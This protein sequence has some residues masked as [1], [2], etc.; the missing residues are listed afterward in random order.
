MP[1]VSGNIATLSVGKQ[2][3]KGT[4]QATPTYKMKLTG[5]NPEAR[6]D[7]IQLA[8]TDAT[9]QQGATVV[10][11]SRVEGT[12]EHYIRPPSFGL[13]AYLLM[14][15]NADSGAGPY[16]HTATP[17]NSSPYATLFKAIG[18]TVLVD[19]YSDC[20]VQSLTARGAAGGA[21]TCSVNWLGLTP[22]H[23]SSDPVL[24]A[25]ATTPLVYPDVTVTLAASTAAI[26]EGFEL[27]ID[28][29]TQMIQGDT[30]LYNSDMAHGELQ[31]RGTLTMLFESDAEYRRHLTGTPSGTVPTTSVASQAL[32]IT[33]S[34]GAT[35]IVSFV[36]A[37]VAWTEVPVNPDPGGAP[38]KV[39]AGFYSLPQAA[40]GDYAK[41][42][43]TN[44]VVTY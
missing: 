22:L 42:I 4:P 8:E 32:T 28:N 27:T 24:T 43:T 16:V 21:L 3:A 41:I 33:A 29:Q 6:R 25:E 26:V 19:Q 23:G 5:G 18:G 9:R 36:F 37:G 1:G 39:A 2:T 17:A 10:V 20:W 40:I 11:G 15:A 30:G 34:A 14:G 12:S 7:T 38:I 44:S 35:A 13:L 31:V